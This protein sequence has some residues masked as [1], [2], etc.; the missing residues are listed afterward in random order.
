[1]RLSPSCT[2]G[3][4]TIQRSK[5]GDGRG[6][7]SRRPTPGVRRPGGTH[8]HREGGGVTA[9]PARRGREVVVTARQ[10][11]RLPERRTGPDHHNTDAAGARHTHPPSHKQYRAAQQGPASL[12]AQSC[13]GSAA[14]P[15]AAASPCPPSGRQSLPAGRP[16]AYL[17]AGRVPLVDDGVELRTG[18]CRTG[19]RQQVPELHRRRRRQ[20]EPA[21]TV[22]VTVTF[23]QSQSPSVTFPQSQSPSQP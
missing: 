3:V 16:P 7:S 2:H 5:L 19:L 6:R 10:L 12:A 9:R 18:V 11:T 15:A 4:F 21:V 22:T 17:P 20:L 23:P 1:M 14:I 8:T 13:S